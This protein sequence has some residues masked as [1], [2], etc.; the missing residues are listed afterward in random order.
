MRRYIPLKALIAFGALTLFQ[1]NPVWAQSGG[2]A[3]V[4]LGHGEEGHLHLQEMVKHL[5]F[6]LEMPDASDELKTHGPEALKHAK[7]ALMHYDEA[8]K[9]AS[10]SLGRKPRPMMEGSDHDHEGSGGNQAQP[11]RPEGSH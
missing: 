11:Q 4:G 7:E 1:I 3:S 5:E 8:L 9:H 2:H 6:S 10:E